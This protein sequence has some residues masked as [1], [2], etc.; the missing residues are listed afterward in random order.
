M[1]HINQDNYSGFEMTFSNGWKVSV[2]FGP[3]TLS[4][5]QNATGY[6][7]STTAEI[8]AWDNTNTPYMFENTTDGYLGF[9]STDKVADFITYIR[10]M[11]SV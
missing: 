7:N 10:N 4:D 6:H 3:G 9:V 1:L 8:R 2:E 11:E 5:N